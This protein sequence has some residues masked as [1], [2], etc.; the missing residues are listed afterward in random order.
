MAKYFIGID[1]G[2]QSSKVVVFDESGQAV[3]RGH[4]PLRPYATPQP[5]IVLHPDD[6]LW[7]SIGAAS[8]MAMADFDA[9]SKDLSGVGLCTIRCCRAMLR[10]DGTLV[11]PVLSWMDYRSGLA[12]EDTD[13]AVA[14]V[15]T[16]SGYISARMTGNFVDTVANTYPTWPIDTSTWTWSNS[17]EA[18]KAFGC[19]P[20]KLF[21]LVMPGE[22]LG[23]ITRAAS[24]HLG[25][26]EGIPVFATSNDKA[27]EALGCGLRNP[28]EILVSLGTYIAGM[29]VGSTN[30]SGTQHFWTN[31]GCRPFQYLYES[32]GIR[33]GMWTLS[34]VRDLLGAEM[35][36]SAR[37]AGLSVEEYLNQQ[38][39]GVPCGSDGLIA[40]LD[41]LAPAAEPHR[42]GAFLGF[43][44]RQGR[45]HMYR[46]VLEAIAMTMT[47]RIEAMAEELGT[48]F[49]QVVVSGGGSSSD[50]MMS[51][52]AD[53][54]GIPSVRMLWNNAASLGAAIC[55]GVGSGHFSSFDDAIDAMVRAGDRFEPDPENHK[56]YSALRQVIPVAARDLD[57]TNRM[58]YQI[59]Q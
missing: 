9:D 55:A 48:K 8:R 51:I 20:E 21:D 2:S 37:S 49:D 46:S 56:T 33:R 27:V 18:I 17:A 35:V 16:S 13:P 6:D 4:A 5:G 59:V 26:P 52:M 29:S 32:N 11:S 42:K 57:L 15:T 44:G 43:D 36:D 45:M 23:Q 3:A 1:N 25:I 30:L 38:A 24:A 47:N 41:W 28:A 53:S 7:D 12:Y 40:V 54:F 14:K 31:L 50:L 34:W 19:P 58:L 22:S 10:A 39:L